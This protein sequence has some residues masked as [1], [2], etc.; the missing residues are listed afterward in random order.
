MNNL[1]VHTLLVVFILAYAFSGGI[2]IILQRQGLSFIT[3]FDKALAR[4]SILLVCGSCL[5]VIA[6]GAW[7]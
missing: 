4:G 1:L 2:F 7:M 6:Y 5:D 3:S